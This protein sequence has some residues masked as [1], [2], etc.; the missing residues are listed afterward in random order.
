MTSIFYANLTSTKIGVNVLCYFE[1][2]LNNLGYM[3]KEM[4]MICRIGRCELILGIGLD[5]VKVYKKIVFQT[6]NL[7]GF[8]VQV[9]SF[10]L[11]IFK[12]KGSGFGL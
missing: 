8:K 10:N 5:V 9:L 6:L 3:G 2:I 4:I 7:K 1:Y 12:V 11:I